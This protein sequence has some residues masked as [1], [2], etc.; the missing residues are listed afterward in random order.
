MAPAIANWRRLV[1]ASQGI[2][3]LNITSSARVSRWM[4]LRKH[5]GGMFGATSSALVRAVIK[6]AIHRRL[7]R[8][9]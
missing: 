6:A 7:C 8:C 1:A 5:D 3:V 4:V 9:R 2:S